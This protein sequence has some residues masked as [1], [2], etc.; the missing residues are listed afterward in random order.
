MRSS[1]TFG[2]LIVPSALSVDPSPHEA[3]CMSLDGAGLRVLTR[4]ECIQ[5]LRTV[6]I[7]RV[8]V[9]HRALPMILPVRFH[10]SDDETV[11]FYTQPGTTL[12]RTTDRTVVAFEA[13]GPSDASEPTWSVLV[14][15]LATHFRSPVVVFGTTA[16]G[17][18]RSPGQR[19]ERSRETRSE[20]PPGP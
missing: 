9:S 10:L 19:G 6:A 5:Q 1:D 4:T 12:H 11:V 17:T 8:A 13:E 7:G 2:A 18:H 15:G 3:G 14:H 16:G 20:R